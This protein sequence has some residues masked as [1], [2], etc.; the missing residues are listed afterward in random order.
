MWID[1]ECGK[2]IPGGVFGYGSRV[3]TAPSFGAT[4]VQAGKALTLELVTTVLAWGTVAGFIFCTSIPQ[5]IF[6]RI[7]DQALTPTPLVITLSIIALLIGA[8]AILVVPKNQFL[9]TK[10]AAIIQVKNELKSCAFPIY[11]RYLLLCLGNGVAFYL[12]SKGLVEHSMS[13]WQLAGISAVA[14]IG[15]FV[16]IGVPGGIGVR[17][18][19]LVWIL[20]QYLSVSESILLA[21]SWRVLQVLVELLILGLSISCE[22]VLSHQRAPSQSEKRVNVYS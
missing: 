3:L 21:A 22:Y 7:Q 15:G 8:T 9:R 10:L 14:W 11:F 4:K 12:F 17:E 13:V 18:G 16:A 19:I 6:T 2:W 5:A 1:T 20:S